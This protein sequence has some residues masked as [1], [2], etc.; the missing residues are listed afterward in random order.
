LDYPPAQRDLILDYLFKPSFGAALQHLKVEIGGDAQISCGAEPSSMRTKS[1]GDDDFDRGYEHW[2]MSEAKKRNP[3]IVLLGL[4][5]AFPS[6][7][8]PAGN[9]PYASNAT[10]ANGAEYVARWVDGVKARHNLTIDNVGVFNEQ[11][12]TDSYIHALRRALDAHNHKDVTIVASDRM[13][14]PI[15]GDYMS[16]PQTRS[17]VDALTQHYPHC[18]GSRGAPGPGTDT[19]CG[20][21]NKNALAANNKYGVK[22]W[23]TEDYSCWTDALGAG[24]WAGEVNSN[25]V[26]GNI[27]MTSAW[28]LASAFYPTI[29]FWNEGLLG[30]QEPWS[31]HF[32]PSPT[33]W[34]SAHT[35]Q[36]TVAGVSKYLKHGHGAGAL[37]GGGT[38]V[39]LYDTNQ[40][41]ITIIAETAGPQIGGFAGH[42]CNGNMEYGP[43]TRP[44]QAT[45]ALSNLKGGAAADSQI[46]MPTKLQLW[47][48]RLSVNS[49]SA[50]DAEDHYFERLPD[51][52]VTWSGM[53]GTVT[54][55]LEVDAVYTLTT[56]TT[57]TKGTPANPIPPSA[58]FP[59]PY[60][61][62]HSLMLFLFS[63]LPPI[64]P[65]GQEPGL[66]VPARQALLLLAQAQARLRRRPDRF[67]RFGARGRLR[68]RGPT[69][70][71]VRRFPASRTRA[72]W[73][74]AARRQDR[75]WI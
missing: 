12:Y 72:R 73:T 18:D 3:D 39:S 75:L 14:E 25:Y 10:E 6:Y 22:L 23:S 54:V 50:P 30:A 66:R 34:A 2:L 67:A 26:G 13:W 63:P 43:A 58:P 45:F 74:V 7:V 40:G 53:V 17:V 15:S 28:H 46:L 27:T 59:L 37:S 36:F 16:N 5:F 60:V 32:V 71:Q 70:R 21:S 41:D 1:P 65:P 29:A 48:T 44:Q 8:N 56:V 42:N 9:S 33:L 51:A 35:T 19:Q 11:R 47:R 69:R 64:L 61:A 62:H 31:G 38:Y 57:A 68:R 4:V 55:E 24:V 49:T 20:K 52:I